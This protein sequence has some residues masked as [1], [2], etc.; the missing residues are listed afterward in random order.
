MLSGFL[1]PGFRRGDVLLRSRRLLN[2]KATEWVDF[3]RPLGGKGRSVYTGN[4]QGRPS[5]FADRRTS[6][7]RGGAVIRADGEPPIS[8]GRLPD[9][10][11]DSEEPV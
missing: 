10:C 9:Q 4:D 7:V 8:R 5:S 2:G 1:G 3:L 6:S 11:E